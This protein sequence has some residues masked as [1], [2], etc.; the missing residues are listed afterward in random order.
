MKRNFYILLALLLVCFT[1][2]SMQ[3]F[4]TS[5]TPNKT[6]VAG[7]ESVTVTGG[8]SSI[9]IAG[10]GA[11]SHIQVFTPG[12]AAQVFNQEITT[13]TLTVP[14]S[15]A[16]D[17]IVKVWSNPNPAAFCEN[18][19][20][21]TV[22]GGGGTP[23]P[24]VAVNDN[25][26]TAQGTAV[27]I[28]VLNN[29]N[30]NGTL[31]SIVIASNPANGTVV[32][33]GN[34][35]VYTPRAGFT[36][37]D[38]FTYTISNGNGTSTATV[39]IT[40]T[41][42]TT[43]GGTC[44]EY[45]VSNANDCFNNNW[46]PYGLYVGTTLYQVKD[47]KFKKNSDGTAT[48]T[49]NYTTDGW[50]VIGTSN[51][52]FTGMTT[53][54]PA[55]S[56]K[57]SRCTQGASA[58]GWMYY[59]DFSGTITINGVS[60]SVTRR[61]EAFQVG[62][63]ANWQ[64]IGDLGASGWFTLGNGT[65]GDLNF[66]LSGGTPCGGTVDPCATD[67][68]APTFAG[69][70]TNINL[71]TSGICANASWTAPTA[72]DNCGTPTITQ[73][74]GGANGSCFPVGTTL[75]KYMATDAKGNIS[76]CTFN[77]VVSQIVV[78]PCAT[79][80]TAPT[81]TN[82]PTNINLTT[83]GNCANASWTAPSA[84]DNCGTPTVTQPLGGANGSCFAVGTTLVKYMATDAKGNIAT[85]TFNVVVTKIVIDPCATDA[86]APVIA[87]CPANIVKTPTA[88]GACWTVSWTAP[89]ATD[90][91]SIATV[92]QTAGPANGSCIAPGT[93]TVT[94][95]AKDAKGNAST[96]SF[97]VTV[98]AYLNCAVVTGNTIA[99]ACVNNVP[100]V[101]GSALVGYEFVW[102][103]STTGCPT[104]SS[105]AI[106]GANGQHYALTSRVSATT[107][108]I[109]CAR[110]IGCTTWGPVNESNCVTVYASD[111]AP[112]VCNAPSTPAGW[113]YL[114]VHGTSHYYKWTGSGDINNATARTKCASIGGRLPVIKTSAQNAFIQSKLAGGSCWIGIR[115]SYNSWLWDNNAVASYY[116]WA[117][118]EPNNYQN[119]EGCAQMYSNGSWND[120]AATGYN[121]CIAEI[122]CSGVN[123]YAIGNDQ[124]SMSG[125]SE[126]NR[127]RLEW[128]NNT[129]YKNDFFTVEKENPTSGNFEVLEVVNNKY[130]TDINEFYS[131]YD[132]APTE[133]DN[134]Y[135][136]KVTYVDGTS[137]TS[138]PQTVK[139][140]VSE[141]ISVFPNPATETVAVDLSKYK[142]AAVTISIYN[143]FGQQVLT[144]QVEKAS[145]TVNVDVS[146]NST[147]NYLIRVVSKGK[148][149]ALQQLH[150]AK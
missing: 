91:C 146:Q 66:R 116:N 76:T 57:Y 58:T 75:V 132:N 113:M 121:W 62:V 97:T 27:S 137:K 133:G 102:L 20:P 35:I 33:N 48:L 31:Q 60:S 13:S 110:P 44:T 90:N 10:L 9:S 115:R 51:I 144:Q 77:V 126:V 17:Y 111:C 128:T 108:F 140:T 41:G 73:P 124:I 141:G 101:N 26:T 8:S 49:A 46:Q 32:I 112:A 87:N 37:N 50:N 19:F 96:C 135:R 71:T 88:A 84:T 149:D 143:Q 52:T 74:L 119:N 64:N 24:P 129:G 25:A 29:D 65:V 92:T 67:V 85:C 36:G 120:C 104:Q 100:T 123:V 147:G 40:V 16:G 98:K 81:L 55:G 6:I 150:I 2:L 127:T 56:P 68:T 69:C 18:N 145:G 28:P 80:V 103:S 131:V 109:R 142:G 93:Y 72:T 148:K 63:G 39:N 45:N 12:F 1:P 5:P 117:A 139:F 122:P 34:S 11:Y 4:G 61:G 15:A 53:T 21:V 86:V 114:G 89:T 105:Q 95:T 136:V 107:Y 7:C 125:A 43:G 78:D 106:A 79:D 3:A 38:S 70:P 134:T 47:G 42:G 30:V 138:A 83:S 82:C 118:Y 22:G 59:T 99:K 130:S 23:T 14:V 94:Y 54:A